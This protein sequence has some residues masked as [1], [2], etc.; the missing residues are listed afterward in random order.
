M[1]TLILSIALLISV[2]CFSQ[3]IYSPAEYLKEAKR[4]NV[5]AVTLSPHKLGVGLTYIPK[6]KFNFYKPISFIFS[7][8]SGIYKQLN[9]NTNLFKFNAG[10]SIVIKNFNLNL[11]PCVNLIKSDIKDKMFEE[12]SFEIGLMT[13]INKTYVLF[14]T[15]P[16]NMESKIGFGIGF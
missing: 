16:I 2:N 10:L 12:L 8:E 1:K 9:G 4:N 11:S 6:I 5:I 15:D 13:K 14:S 3:R 7:A